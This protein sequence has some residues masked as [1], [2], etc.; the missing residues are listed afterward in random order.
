MEDKMMMKSNNSNNSNYWKLAFVSYMA[1]FACGVFVGLRIHKEELESYR[2]VYET[3]SSNRW[4][5]RCIKA[6]LASSSLMLLFF[7]AKTTFKSFTQKETIIIAGN[8]EL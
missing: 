4:R 7:G 5:K 6:V 2:S 8:D 3:A 1:T